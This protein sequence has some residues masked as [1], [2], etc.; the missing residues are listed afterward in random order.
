MKEIVI[1]LWTPVCDPLHHKRRVI[2]RK[3]GAKQEK[4]RAKMMDE[5]DERRKICMCLVSALIQQMFLL[6]IFY[7]C[8]T[9]SLTKT[10]SSFVT[11]QFI[12]QEN[13][14]RAAERLVGAAARRSS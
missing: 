4:K 2:R 14:R 10:P 12:C 11:F 7:K 8:D 9:S 13:G 1:S 5:E 3:I 6:L